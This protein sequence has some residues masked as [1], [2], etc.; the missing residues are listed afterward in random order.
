MPIES[1]KPEIAVSPP[2]SFGGGRA[3]FGLILLLIISLLWWRSY[4]HTDIMAVFGSSG[5][6]GG[7][8]SLRGQLLIAFTNIDMGQNRAW[9]AQTQST[10]VDDG[11]Q[12]RTMLIEGISH[13]GS[14][15]GGL[16]GGGTTTTIAPANPPAVSQKWGFLVGR[17]SVNAFEL[18]GKW[19][20]VIG[21]PHWV[22]LPF[23]IW[24]VATWCIRRGRQLKR[25]RKGWC[26]NCGYDLRGIEGRCPECGAGLINEHQD[27]LDRRLEAYRNDPNAGD[28]WE[29]VKR[30]IMDE[31]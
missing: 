21:L 4:R 20:S 27:E 29:T 22:L 19:A 2:Q 7:V 12:L 25:R 13:T 5:K 8:M 24:P 14:G 26:L 28:S 3:F 15:G 23:G 1:E 10:S 18:E 16:F 31:K 30:R 17:H 9:T 6:I 11:N